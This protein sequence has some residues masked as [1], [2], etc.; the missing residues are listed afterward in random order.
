MFGIFVIIQFIKNLKGYYVVYVSICMIFV[1]FIGDFM[2]FGWGCYVN[3][4]M[5]EFLFYI[6]REI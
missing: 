3:V 2:L 6:N 1:E 5:K 4:I